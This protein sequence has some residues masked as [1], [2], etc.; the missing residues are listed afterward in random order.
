LFFTVSDL[1]LNFWATDSLLN[2]KFEAT[3]AKVNTFLE[4]LRD[5]VW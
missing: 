4:P 5:W 2:Q 1:I 3:W